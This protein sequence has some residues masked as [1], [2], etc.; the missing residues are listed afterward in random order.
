MKSSLSGRKIPRCDHCMATGPGKRAR[1]ASGYSGGDRG[2]NGED[3]RY[4]LKS[5]NERYT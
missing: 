2:C 4:R 3:E 5:N 1:G